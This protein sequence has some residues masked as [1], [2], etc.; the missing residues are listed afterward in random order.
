MY[1]D[2]NR[3]SRILLTLYGTYSLILN[4]LVGIV[5]ASVIH[6]NSSRDSSKLPVIV[7]VFHH[8]TYMMFYSMIMPLAAPF[9]L[10]NY[11]VHKQSPESI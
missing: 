5:A 1:E 9:Y 2:L 10:F 8:I 3:N 7:R 11:V 4:G 6:N